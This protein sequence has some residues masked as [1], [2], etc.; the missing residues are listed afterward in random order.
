MVIE[1]MYLFGVEFVELSFA[2]VFTPETQHFGFG[3]VG[4]VDELFEPPS[5]AY[6]AFDAA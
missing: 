3:T 6:F 1:E 4:H 5:I 2:F